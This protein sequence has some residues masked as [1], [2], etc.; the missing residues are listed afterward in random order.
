MNRVVL[1]VCMLIVGLVGFFGLYL[2]LKGARRVQLAIASTKWPIVP[3][4]VLSSDDQKR[5]SEDAARQVTA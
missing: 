3:G 2:F 5:L 4:K 1:A